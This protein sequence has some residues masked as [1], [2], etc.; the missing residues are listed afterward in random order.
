MSAECACGL[1][2]EPPA[3]TRHWHP[4]RDIPPAT[5]MTVVRFGQDPALRRAV[6]VG[7]SAYWTE[8]GYMVNYYADRTPPMLWVDVGTCWA[9]TKHPVVAASPQAQSCDHFTNRRV[10]AD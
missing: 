9:G 7:A 8:H 1:P 5:V 10:T 4:T 3:G 2:L 6:R